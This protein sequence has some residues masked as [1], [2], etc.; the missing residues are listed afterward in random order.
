MRI[1]LSGPITGVKNHLLNFLRAETL[2]G[3]I[4]SLKALT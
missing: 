1:Y 2:S 3:Q 4:S